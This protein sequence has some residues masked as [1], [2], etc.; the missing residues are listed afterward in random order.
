[1]AVLIAKGKELNSLKLR[2]LVD[3]EGAEFEGLVVCDVFEKAKD[4]TAT[5]GKNVAG[6]GGWTVKDFTYL[7][8]EFQYILKGTEEFEVGGKTFAA[9]A[10][11]IVHIQKGTT[12]TQTAKPG[13]ELIFLT[14]PGFRAV[15]FHIKD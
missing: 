6:K 5:I 15:G 10:G 1:M 13:C 11:D 14:I 4:A 12:M 7:Y 9:H 8:D 2:Q 3:S